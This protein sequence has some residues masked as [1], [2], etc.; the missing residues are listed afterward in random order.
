MVQKNFPITRTRFAPSPTGELH[1]GGV[2]TALFNYLL[3][4]QNQGQFIFRVEDTDQERSR[5]DFIFK[6]HQDLCWLGLKPDESVF[7]PGTCGPYRQTQ[8]LPIYQKYVN[9]LIQ[10]KK[11]YYC[12]CSMAELAAEKDEYIQKIHRKNYQYSRKCLSLTEDQISLF[13]QTKKEYLIRFR[14]PRQNVYRL[15]DSVRGSVVFRGQDIEDFVIYRS[16]G[17]PTFYFA[18]V[19]DDYLMQI[20]HVLRGEEHLT[21]TAKQ[22]VICQALGWNPPLFAHLSTIVNSEGKKMSKR[23]EKTN[24]F[25]NVYQ[26]REKGYLPDAVINYLLLLGWNPKTS[27]EFFSLSEAIKKFN[28]TGLQSHGAAFNIE[29]LNW[30]NRHYIQQLSETEYTEPAWQFLSTHY[31]LKPE[32]REWINQIA[33]LFK[34]HLDCFHKLIDLSWFFFQAPPFL[35]EPNLSF[36]KKELSELTTWEEATISPVLKKNRSWLPNLRQKLTGEKT[37]P[38]LIK[39]IVLLGKEETLA[40]I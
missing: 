29:K 23:D 12:F 39:I 11:A 2:R 22:L 17:L 30:F 27:Q 13:L 1:I 10:T 16:N 14:V 6:Q 3:A 26:L 9:Q 25:Q 8:R 40:R 37:G 24:Q 4:K 19:I 36:L 38:E 31:N 21:N 35:R 18:V 15:N 7:N 28:L 33:L 34:P 32:K 5:E 20:T